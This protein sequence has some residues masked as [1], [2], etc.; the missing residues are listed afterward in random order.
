MK[1]FAEITID[2]VVTGEHETLFLFSDQ[3]DRLCITLQPASMHEGKTYTFKKVST[4]R[5]PIRFRTEDETII[6]GQTNKNRKATFFIVE[7]GTIVRFISDG[8][9]WAVL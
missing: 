6:F 5:N 3:T 8:E 2:Y 9:K 7:P 1:M 4:D